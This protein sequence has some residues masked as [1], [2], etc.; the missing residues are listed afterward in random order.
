LI[1]EDRGFSW[2]LVG[3]LGGVSGWPVNPSRAFGC[4]PETSEKY[5]LTQRTKEVTETNSCKKET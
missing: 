1:F 5:N 4:Q 2:F 3:R